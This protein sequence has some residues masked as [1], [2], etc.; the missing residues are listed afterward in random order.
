[1]AQEESRKECR[2][3]LPFTTGVDISP[4]ASALSLAAMRGAT[5]VAVSFIMAPDERNVRLEL[6]QQSQ[7]FLE[8]LRYKALRLAIPVECYEVFTSDILASIAT[9]VHDLACQS[10]I[11]VSEGEKTLFLHQREMRQLLLNPPASLVLLRFSPLVASGQPRLTARLLGWVQRLGNAVGSRKR[12]IPLN[13]S[14]DLK[15]SRNANQPFEASSLLSLYRD[16]SEL[17][18]E[19]YRKEEV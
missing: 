19:K 15:Q 2:W 12:E 5:L 9:Q 8:A 4:I 14:L 3:L 6:L 16:T 17:I 1:M 18:V 13:A 7:D 11:L 10:L